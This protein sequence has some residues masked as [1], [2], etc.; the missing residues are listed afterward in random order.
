MSTENRSEN[1]FGSTER[2]QLYLSQSTQSG[3]GR[4]FEMLADTERKL[5]LANE[6]ENV[7]ERFYRRN[8][9]L[10]L[11]DELEAEIEEMG[12]FTDLL[13]DDLE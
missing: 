6:N 1:P 2:E 13:G 10:E 4:L 12:D 9:L 7:Y 11:R 3:R 8:E 5:E